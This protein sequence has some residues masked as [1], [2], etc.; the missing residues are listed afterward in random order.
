MHPADKIL[1][2]ALATSPIP[3][4]EWERVRVGLRDRAFFSARVE[5]LR[6]LQAAR[7]QTAALLRAAPRPDGALATPRSAASAIMEEARRQ[8]IATGAGGLTDPGSA[9]RAR[10]IVETNA[11]LASG[12]ARHEADS[13][14]GALA[15]FPGRE[16]FRALPRKHERKWKERWTAAGGAV[17][18]GRM[19][20][21][22]GDP[23]WTRISRFGLPYP[24]FDYG[25]GMAVRPVSRRE[26]VRLGLIGDDWTP[27]AQ[28]PHDSLNQTLEAT[29]DFSNDSDWRFL[30]ASF[31]DQVR[32]DGGK[33]IWRTDLVARSFQSG[34]PFSI[35]LGEP[36]GE[37][38]SKLPDPG[39]AKGKAL[40][41]T[42]D[43][44]DKERPD[45][46]DQR[47]H[48]RP[49]ASHPGDIPLTVADLE[50]IPLIWRSPD[51]ALP[52]ATP[53]T[54]VLELDALAGGKYRLVVEFAGA[55]RIKTYYREG[56]PAQGQKKSRT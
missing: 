35:R 31:G 25:S 45:G 52:G 21:L 48:F 33:V 53:T 44:L 11:G 41:V 46:T 2:Q 15:A 55:P 14:P 49:P 39:I 29:L 38:L 3:S 22:L 36:G 30:K 10:V 13:A 50:L 1:Q 34:E 5:S 56:Q 43:W 26:C 42:Q 51:R 9:A 4:S 19:V 6:F 24:P 20:A 40:T 47:A 8:G 27:P 23:V 12:Y 28:T 37:L 7:A 32:K 54:S 18:E 17:R 16:L